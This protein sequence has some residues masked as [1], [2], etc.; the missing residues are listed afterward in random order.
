[1]D[2]K[3][4]ALAHFPFLLMTRNPPRS[5]LS[6]GLGSAILMGE[7]ALH[8]EVEEAVCLE[9]SPSVIEA[10]RLF[11]TFNHSVLDN[12]KV[13]VINDDGVNFLRRSDARFDA[14]ISDA[15]SRTTHA[16][17]ATFFSLDYYRLGREHLTPHGLMI[18]WI[19]LDLPPEEL[20]T[21]LRTFLHVFPYGYVWVAPPQSL[22]VVG[23]E[24]PLTLEPARVREV[25]EAPA[26]ANLRRYG[27][28]QASDFVG[29]LTAD[30]ASLRSWLNEGTALNSLG[31]PV[32]EFYS[33]RAHA[34]PPTQRA[35]RNLINLLRGRGDALTTVELAGPMPRAILDGQLALGWLAQAWRALEGGQAG[36]S[37]EALRLLGEARRSAASNRVVQHG[38]AAGYRLVLRREP[39]NVVAL[40][41]LGRVLLSMGRLDRALARFRQALDI[42]PDDPRALIGAAHVLALH[43]D[44]GSRDPQQ[45]VRLAARAV[46]LTGQRDPRMLATLADTYFA[47]G[48]VD[49]ALEAVR[50][51]L[52]L[53]EAESDRTLLGELRTREE[54][55]AMLNSSAGP[56][57][58][59]EEAQP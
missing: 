1:V 57:A 40:V 12:R 14:I 2:H 27:I 44:P 56:S 32:L 11:E 6:V 5:V 31:H 47:A 7:V 10:A 33:L 4:Q 22:F 9:I 3:Q 52:P 41:E 54:V 42:D 43:V 38:A 49:L 48:R 34:V 13:R 36:G 20:S 51:A 18:Q 53:A 16:A 26:T 59:P 39:R 35:E 29:A 45:A 50:I 24:Q 58:A 8:R 23:S 15:K 30:E 21:I 19:P 17:N 46:E 55:L 37:G 28:V 25:L